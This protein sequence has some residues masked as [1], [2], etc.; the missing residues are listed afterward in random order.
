[1]RRQGG[2]TVSE[3]LIS[4]SIFF[5]TKRCKEKAIDAGFTVHALIPGLN[6]PHRPGS[7]PIFTQSGWFG[8]SADSLQ[9]SREYI[10]VHLDL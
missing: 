3:K 5:W 10:S 8:P 4:R 1:M 7:T 9:S 2:I 6:L